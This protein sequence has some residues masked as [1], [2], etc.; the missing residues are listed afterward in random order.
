MECVGWLIPGLPQGVLPNENS[1]QKQSVEAVCPV[2]A[3]G[4]HTA[5]HKGL[6]WFARSVCGA[7]LL[8]TP[9]HSSVVRHHLRH[10]EQRHRSD[11]R[12]FKERPYT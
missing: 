10:M 2:W 4:G 5:H 12:E 1:G 6:L 3:S 7:H 9:A 8:Q 11:A